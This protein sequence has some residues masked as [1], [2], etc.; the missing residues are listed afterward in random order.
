MSSLLFLDAVYKV[1]SIF[2]LLLVRG[3]KSMVS[4]KIRDRTTSKIIENI[5]KTAGKLN[6][7]KQRPLQGNGITKPLS[8][9]CTL[10]FQFTMFI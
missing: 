10:L 6:T 3:T 8:F 4:K 2:I 1:K 9:M 5:K 7:T